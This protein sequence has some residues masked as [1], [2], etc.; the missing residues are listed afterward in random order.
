[1]DRIA[2]GVHYGIPYEDASR[3]DVYVSV[4]RKRQ[5]SSHPHRVGAVMQAAG[6]SRPGSY[7]ETAVSQRDI[8]EQLSSTSRSGHGGGA[9]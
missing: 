1:M 7:A 8:K 2:P 4:D 3:I 5:G 9:S 6:G